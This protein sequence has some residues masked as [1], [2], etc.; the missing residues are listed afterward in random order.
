MHHSER[1]ALDSSSDYRAA[2]D[3]VIAGEHNKAIA[4]V[5]PLRTIAGAAWRVKQ[6]KK[7]IN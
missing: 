6:D 1:D 4:L 3:N 2:L 5:I 7:F